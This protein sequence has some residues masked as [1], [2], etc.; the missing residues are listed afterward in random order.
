MV[1]RSGQLRFDIT[2]SP[3]LVRLPKI[4]AC[5]HIHKCPP[6]HCVVLHKGDLVFRGKLDASLRCFLY[7]PHSQ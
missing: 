3:V 2:L 6:P 4:P 1:Y 5:E 7:V